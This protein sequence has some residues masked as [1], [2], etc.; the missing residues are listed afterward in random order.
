MNHRMKSLLA[1]VLAGVWINLSE[2]FRNQFVLG[3]R[4]VA[5]FQSLGMAFPSNMLNGIVWVVWGFSLGVAVFVLSRKFTLVLTTLL[6]W[7][8][9]FVMMWLVLWNLR[10]LPPGIILYAAPL[11]LLEAF[12]AS[13]ICHKVSR[14]SVP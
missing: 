2:F 7:L 6:A 10:V 13:Y 4:W 11:S 12:V 5:H 14:T 9:G 3:E 8:L 1:V